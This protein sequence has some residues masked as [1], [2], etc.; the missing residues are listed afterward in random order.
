MADIHLLRKSGEPKMQ[1]A[2]LERVSGVAVPGSQVDV[3]PVFDRL[4]DHPVS[5]Q[6]HE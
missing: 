5:D 2:V 4:S 6:R 1:G 3:M